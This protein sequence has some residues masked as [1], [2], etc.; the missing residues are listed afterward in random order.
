MYVPVNGV[1][2]CSKNNVFLIASIEGEET[3][4]LIHAVMMY[5]S[6][7]IKLLQNND[8]RFF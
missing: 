2:A 5:L 8:S 3:Q 6:T 1:N 4:P 7:E